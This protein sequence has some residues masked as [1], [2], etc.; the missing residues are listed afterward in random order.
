MVFPLNCLFLIS[1]RADRAST[2]VTNVTNLFNFNGIV[3][4][5]SVWNQEQYAEERDEI[6]EYASRDV[7]GLI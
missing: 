5:I 7:H 1:A 4:R 3:D 2:S 6:A